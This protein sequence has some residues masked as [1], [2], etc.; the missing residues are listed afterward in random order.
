MDVR[1]VYFVRILKLFPHPPLKS[2]PQFFDENV[3]KKLKMFPSLWFLLAAGKAADT[4]NNKLG[5]HR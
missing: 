5:Q 4:Q 2:L 1:G 3:P